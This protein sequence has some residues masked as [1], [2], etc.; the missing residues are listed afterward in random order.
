LPSSVINCAGAALFK[1]YSKNA[2]VASCQQLP[3]G[4]QG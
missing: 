1:V 2:Q 3:D 4:E